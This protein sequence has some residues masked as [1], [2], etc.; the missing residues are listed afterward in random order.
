MLEKAELHRFVRFQ[1]DLSVSCAYQN[2]ISRHSKLVPLLEGRE[3]LFFRRT[4]QGL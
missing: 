3:Q 2:A 1:Y 4:T